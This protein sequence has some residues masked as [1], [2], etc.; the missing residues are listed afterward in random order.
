MSIRVAIV[1]TGGIAR[2]QHFPSLAALGDRVVI[3]AVTDTDPA[4]ARSAA[5]EF[6]VPAVY[7]DLPGLLAAERPDVVVLATPPIA[8][9]AQAIA[10]L[11]AGAWV[12]SEKPPTLS[13]AEYDE[14]AEHEGENGPF[15]SYIF[16]HRF[17]S[18]AMRLR[19]LIRDGELGRA[20]VAQCNTLWFRPPEYLAVPWRGKW[21]TEGGGP[22]M[23]LGIHQMDL[24]LSLLG[25]WSE[26][27]A[28]MA[29]LDRETEME[30]VAMATVRFESGAMCSI[31]NS[32][33]SP[34][35]S[36][37]VRIDFERGSFEL[38][39]L[40]GYDND[41]WTVT[42]ATGVDGSGWA[43]AENVSSNTHLPPF[44]SV[45]DAFERGARPDP[46]VAEG[47]RTLELVAA[48][49]KSAL[50]RRAVARAELTPEDP[51]YRS[52]AG[53]D[54][55]AATAAIHANTLRG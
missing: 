46:L 49:Y 34:R 17:G 30:D 38:E 22:T 45:I 12:I 31:T 4:S 9:R 15:V 40:Y 48:M 42:P 6:G 7:D 1:G 27:S 2:G 29:T 37:Q 14:I 36:S 25:D 18:A 32:M 52:M 47:R 5:D 51:F 3:V 41:N 43:P 23:G 20:L 13:L 11:D 39:H 28:A 8:H 19:E 54:P 26:I 35:E 21:Q 44:A 33:L 24:L 55:A 53:A 10:A 16:Q 50:E